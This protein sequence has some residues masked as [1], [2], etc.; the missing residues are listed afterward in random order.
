M[1]EPEIIRLK[2]KIQS[3]TE[4]NVQLQEQVQEL[5]LKIGEYQARNIEYQNKKTKRI[6]KKI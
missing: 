3:L 2:K 5:S 1:S 4:F 6:M